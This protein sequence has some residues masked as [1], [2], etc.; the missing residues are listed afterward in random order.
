MNWSQ[1]VAPGV[2]AMRHKARHKLG[3]LTT[4][5]ELESAAHAIESMAA[6]LDAAR[7]RGF[8]MAWLFVLIA[9]AAIFGGR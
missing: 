8:L 3:Y 7:T 5:A 1:R 2:E 4:S 6:K 9:L